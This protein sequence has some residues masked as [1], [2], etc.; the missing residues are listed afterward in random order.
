MIFKEQINNNLIG[1]Y[2]VY[3]TPLKIEVGRIKS[4]N[5]KWIFVVYNCNDDWDDYKSYTGVPTSP[6]NLNIIEDA[7][8]DIW[9]KEINRNKEALSEL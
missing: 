8:V 3:T 2:A 4:F 9:I 7:E 5:D 1:K 6:G